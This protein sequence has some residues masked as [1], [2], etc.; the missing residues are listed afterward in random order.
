MNTQQIAEL[1]K[2]DNMRVDYLTNRVFRVLEVL[3]NCE[4]ASGHASYTHEDIECIDTHIRE[5]ASSRYE[6]HEKWMARTAELLAK[7][8]EDRLRILELERRAKEQRP[9]ELMAQPSQPVY[10]PAWTVERKMQTQQEDINATYAREQSAKVLRLEAQIRTS[11]ALAADRVKTPNEFARHSAD[12]RKELHETRRAHQQVMDDLLETF[13]EILTK[14]EF[15][16]DYT[17]KQA[18]RG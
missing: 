9:S 11:D 18:T 14:A 13:Q 8:E 5:L 1:W 3:S 10:Q 17:T 4:R 7:I 16:I 2:T 6:W 15:A 12:L